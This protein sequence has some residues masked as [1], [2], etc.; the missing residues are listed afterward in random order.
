MILTEKVK[1]NG[2]NKQISPSAVDNGGNRLIVNPITDALNFRYLSSDYGD[3]LIG[4]SIRGNVEV[5]NGSLPVGDNTCVWWC[6]DKKKNCIYYFIHN[7][8]SN[9]CIF[10]Y[11][12]ATD[13][14]TLLIQKSELGF[15]LAYGQRVNSASVI[16]DLLIWDDGY[17]NTGYINTT[18]DYTYAGF[19]NAHIRINRFQPYVKPELN[20][21]GI[22][23]DA[24][25]GNSYFRVANVSIAANTIYDKSLQFSY[26][27]I[28]LDNE[29]SNLAPY[30]DLSWG[31]RFADHE[32]ST[33]R[34]QVH[35]RVVL[36]NAIVYAK[37]IQ[38]LYREGTSDSWK[39][40]ANMNPT[41]GS[42]YDIYYT[43]TEFIEEV[44]E[45]ES[46]KIFESTPNFSSA[47]CVQKNRLFVVDNE[48]G[49][50]EPNKPTLNITSPLIRKESVMAQYWLP[51]GR[52]KFGIALFDGNQK[53]LGVISPTEITHPIENTGTFNYQILLAHSFSN[54]TLTTGSKTFILTDKEIASYAQVGS[55][56]MISEYVG[57]LTTPLMSGTITAKNAAAGSITVNVTFKS[58]VGSAANWVIKIARV[59]STGFVDAKRRVQVSISGGLSLNTKVRYYSIVR[60][61][62]LY[63]DDYIEIPVRPFFYKF[64]KTGSYSATASE[65][66]IDGKVFTKAKPASPDSY[67]KVY[68]QMPREVP[69][70]VD[71]S[72]FIRL[73]S[74]VNPSAESIRVEKV[75]GVDGDYLIV[76]NF[77]VSNW[78]A[79]SD[80]TSGSDNFIIKVA[81]YRVRQSE[82][83]VRFYEITARNPVDGTG[84]LPVTVFAD[85]PGDVFYSSNR[86]T[87]RS[88]QN[89]VDYQKKENAD[90]TIFSLTPVSIIGN[91][92]SRQPPKLKGG[93]KLLNRILGARGIDEVADIEELNRKS[94]ARLSKIVKKDSP[95]FK[96]YLDK[97]IDNYSNDPNN[98]RIKNV[99]TGSDGLSSVNRN[100]VLD[101]SK[102][103]WNKG[104]Q[105]IEIDPLRRVFRSDTKIRF[106]NKYIQDS[107]VNGLNSFDAANAHAVPNDRGKTKRLIPVGNN[108]L[109]VHERA[110]TTL[111]I[112]EGIISSASGDTALSVT[113]D[114]IAHDNKM[115][116]E[117]GSYHPESVVK[118][119]LGHVFGFDIYKGVPW[120]YTNEGL[121]NIANGKMDEYFRDLGQEYLPLKDTCKIIGGIDPYHKEYILTFRK[122]DGTGVTWAFNY[123]KDQWSHRYSFIPEMYANIGNTL[124]SFKN[125]RLWKHNASDTHNNFYGVQY[126]RQIDIAVNSYPG[127][128]KVYNGIIIDAKTLSQDVDEIIARFYC[129]TQE[130]YLRYDEF[131]RKEDVHL[132]A[133][134]RD[135]NTPNI[136]AGKIALRDGDDLRGD[137]LTVRLIGSLTTRAP[138]T[139][140]DITY[141]KSEFSK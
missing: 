76:N 98:I 16:D 3:E 106:S 37:K 2:I 69:I 49:F 59:G 99:L 136:D 25:K 83:A 127:T 1:F 77:N 64:D 29:V 118:N 66:V 81:V 51:G 32:P 65:K 120:R 90:F 13:A 87:F 14:I 21:S 132:S 122:A 5:V 60:S 126:G 115:L 6:E 133:I 86:Y 93:D 72:Y 130:S 55:S 116:L 95:R 10:K 52:K 23:V 112:E 71:T 96:E 45:T 138:I 17:N 33:E 62:E 123:E 103:D 105:L 43:G 38:L 46:S 129:G 140:F 89:K 121:S 19:T 88:H 58:G 30:S 44:P 70:A 100:F 22:P 8:N 97:N 57:S 113:K 47:S 137:Y 92:I 68:L 109:N 26:R 27:I 94:G 9:H 75:I 110:C 28:Y 79:N 108:I 73:I 67:S 50:D 128:K 41:S 84:T 139:C 125:G 135:I 78:S 131:D 101:Y 117:Y 61:D 74:G 34:V 31:D 11:V 24:N 53:S 36:S 85:L 12:P 42:N 80:V 124:I 119:D 7:S 56:V 40:F 18:R 107:N 35:V 20:I 82:E 15:Q 114:V 91:D 4:E 39:V 134:L 104:I 48:S 63:F 102:A 54:H 111:Y 141:N